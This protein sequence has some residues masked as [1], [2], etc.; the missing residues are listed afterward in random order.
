MKNYELSIVIPFYNEEK[1]I[2]PLADILI[3]ELKKNNINYELV[4]VNNG[5]SDST[6]KIVDKLSNKYKDVKSVHVEINQGYGWGILNGLR[7]ATGEYV[8]YMDGDLEISPE[9]IIKLY[10]RIKDT[11]ADIG[12]GIRNHRE[13]GILKNIASSGF[14]VLFFILYSKF[15]KQVNANPKIMRKIC[16]EKMNLKSKDWFI[17]TEII[18]NGLENN[19]KI[20]DHLVFYTPRES[21]E[22]HIG[23]FKLF[24]TIAEYF[25]NIIKFKFFKN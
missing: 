10:K 18:I 4:L 20:V 7:V 3:N 9:D 13:R 11:N 19:Y 6:P 25:K 5:S 17:D 8:G 14:D 2:E 16:Y 21:G 1:T 23:F 24:S 22:S 15:I 12:K